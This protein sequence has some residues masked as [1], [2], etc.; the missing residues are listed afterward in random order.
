MCITTHIK[1]IWNSNI[2]NKQIQSKNNLTFDLSLHYFWLITNINICRYFTFVTIKF[3][4]HMI[5]MKTKSIEPNISLIN[6]WIIAYN[7]KWICH[8]HERQ[9]QK[10]EGFGIIHKDVPMVSISTL[11]HW[12]CGRM[13]WL[14]VCHN[15]RA[16]LC[17]Q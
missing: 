14:N 1:C 13:L 3:T 6:V 16:I 11:L 8:F 5:W 15:V 4:K 9:K 2:L 17:I 7:I 10:S 12:T